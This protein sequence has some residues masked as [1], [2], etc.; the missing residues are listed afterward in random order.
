VEVIKEQ[1]AFTALLN[2]WLGAKPADEELKARL[3]GAAPKSARNLK[4][5]SG[6]AAN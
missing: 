4:P 3:L 2:I 5:A 1:E 6:E